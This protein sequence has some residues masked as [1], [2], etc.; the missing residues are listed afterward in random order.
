MSGPGQGP[1]ADQARSDSRGARQTAVRT[2]LVAAA[3]VVGDQLTK[4]LVRAE[5]P[6][7][8]SRE[9]FLGIELVHTRNTGVAFSMFSGGGTLVVLIGRG[10]GRSRLAG[11]PRPRRRA[12]HALGRARRLI[13]DLLNAEHGCGSPPGREGH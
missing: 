9:L 1:V 4:A 6:R 3:V 7:F 11:C 2:A 10:G 5:I 12:Q 13:R 8:D